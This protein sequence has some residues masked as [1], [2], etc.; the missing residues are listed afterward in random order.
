[1]A[2]TK[3]LEILG[4]LIFLVPLTVQAQLVEMTSNQRARS[5]HVKAYRYTLQER[6][7]T[8]TIRV[9]NPRG[10]LQAMPVIDQAIHPR[11]KIDFQFNTKNWLPGHYHVVVRG[12]HTQS[13]NRF[14]IFATRRD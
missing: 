5:T 9:I 4:C 6:P 13:N 8:V 12:K 11:E 14:K 7:D 3:T 1:M 10:E 2:M